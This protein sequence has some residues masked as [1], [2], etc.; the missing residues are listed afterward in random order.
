MANTTA[1]GPRFDAPARYRI[2]VRG[3]LDPSW[4]DRLCDLTIRIDEANGTTILEGNLIDQ[5]ALAGVLATLN[6]LQ[7]ALLDVTC[8]DGD[9]AASS[10]PG[11][12]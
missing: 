11:G 9:T 5:A 3:R 4:A 6:D 7:L 2:R 12:T 1:G 10:S 8:L